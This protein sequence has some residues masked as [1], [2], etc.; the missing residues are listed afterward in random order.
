MAEVKR[1]SS[2]GNRLCWSLQGLRLTQ[3]YTGLSAD[4]AGMG[5]PSL[6]HWLSK[7]VME[8]AKKFS[9]RTLPRM[10]MLSFVPSSVIWRRK[11][12]P[13]L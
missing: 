7:F 1:G 6:N 8:V 11:M 10:F 5:A 13:K 4:I 12:D 3:G 9:G 2:S